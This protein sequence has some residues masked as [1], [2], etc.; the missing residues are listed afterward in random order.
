[1]TACWTGYNRLPCTHDV[2]QTAQLGS[3][4]QKVFDLEYLCK[5]F[6]KY[7]NLKSAHHED[8]ETAFAF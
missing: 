7:K 8:F 2:F 6:T 1:M 5:F 4:L 3:I